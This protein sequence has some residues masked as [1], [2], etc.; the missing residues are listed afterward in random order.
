MATLRDKIP[1]FL[2]LEHQAAQILQVQEERGF[3]F[4]E[5]AA[6]KLASALEEE[7]RQIS[8]LLQ[9]RH[10]YIPTSEFSPS[11]SNKTRGYVQG[12]PFTRITELNITS[13]DH[14]SW[15]LQ[16][17]YGWKPEK[18]T[19]TG[20]PVIDEI[21]LASLNYPVAAQFC[22]GTDDQEDPWNDVARRERLAQA[23]YE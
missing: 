23:E 18:K 21:V 16:K 12:C 20:K 9:S 3:R 5:A 17:H 8:L 6:W 4:D 15:V 22:A 14:I 19:T 11:R 7:L 1:E 2:D 13:R 10:P